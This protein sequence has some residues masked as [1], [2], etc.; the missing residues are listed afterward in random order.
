MVDRAIFLR[1]CQDRGLEDY[2]RLRALVNGDRIYPRLD[3][4]VEAAT[5]YH[6]GLFHFQTKKL[7]STCFSN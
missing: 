2:G 7:Q 4:L 5:R 6:S 1:I 3:Q